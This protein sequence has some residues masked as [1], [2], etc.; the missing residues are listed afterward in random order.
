MT[1]K[2]EDVRQKLL[3]DSEVKKAYEASKAEFEIAHALIEAR[4]QAK[5]SQREV[6]ERMHTTQ[7]VIAR[8]E[9]GRHLPSL[10]TLY[11]YAQAVNKTIPLSIHPNE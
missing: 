8:L 11:K 3:S 1:I 7:S 9:S 6:A 10:Q 5:M 2:Y 4:L